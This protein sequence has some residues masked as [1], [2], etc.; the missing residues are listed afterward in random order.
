V[1]PDLVTAEELFRNLTPPKRPNLSGA[2]SYFLFELPGQLKAG[3]L[4]LAVRWVGSTVVGLESHDRLSMLGEKILARAW[5]DLDTPGVVEAMTEAYVHLAKD[6]AQ[7]LYPH[8]SE[9]AQ[10]FAD[11]EKR[12]RLAESIANRAPELVTTLRWQW[13]QLVRS[14]D[15]GECMGR[16]FVSV[17]T[18]TE[19]AWATLAWNLVNPDMCDSVL[20]DLLLDARTKSQ[21]FK[22]ESE[23]FFTP[24]DLCSDRA[25]ELKAQ[26]EMMQGWQHK[27]EPQVLEWL[28]RD[29]IRF[30]LERFERGEAAAWWG[31]LREMTLEDTS[32]EY[33][34]LFEQL[35]ITSLPGW[36]L[37]DEVTRV[38]ILDA[39]ERYL[40]LKTPY[41]QKHLLDGQGAED[42]LAVIKAFLVLVQHRP[43]RIAALPED[44]WAHWVPVFLGPFGYGGNRVIMQ[45]L[46]GTAYQHAPNAVVETFAEKLRC[47]IAK[48]GPFLL[49]DALET[50]WDDAI[51]DLLFGLLPEAREKPPCWSGLLEAL[52]RHGNQE[53]VDTARATL[54][55]P[56][57]EAVGERT[58]A[59]KAALVLIRHAP[60]AS[61]SLISPVIEQDR[62]FGRDLIP[63]LAYDVH[64][65][66]EE[67]VHKL[68]AMQLAELFLWLAR[69][70]TYTTDPDYGGAHEFTREDA[71]RELR[72]GLI[73][74]LEK[75]GTPG[76]CQAI[77]H[78]IE[79]HPDLDWVKSV[80]VEAKKNT[81]RETWRP[82]AVQELLSI[83]LKPRSFLVRDAKELQDAL[84]ETLMGLETILQGKQPAARD[85]W[86]KR[87]RDKYVPTGEGHFSDWT[88]RQLEVELKRRGIVADR[89]VVIRQGEGAAPGE[90]TDIYVTAVIPGVTGG[91][92]DQ[93]RVIIEAKGC[94]NRD[95]KTAMET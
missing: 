56:L 54:Q 92:F 13:P 88:S 32:T 23:A 5:E 34:D 50:L 78:I 84:V 59:A 2:Y 33:R 16:L 82:L 3:D 11:T 68:D 86:D 7:M 94:W 37:A 45:A 60:D 63:T 29:R 67:L 12:L 38:R 64:H 42:D 28:P 14:G 22:Q 55:G 6:H 52:A 90:Q 49:P 76:S 39:G 70:Y 95:L 43:N 74:I 80:L 47:D 66:V 25:R 69:E 21:A 61:W 85:L 73:N 4:L 26:Y 15:L 53:A 83:V 72:S 75:S 36:R 19:K 79:A 10:A 17:G 31:L 51:A 44:V 58:L 1:W 18:P 62:S 71:A 81:L 46:V 24:A 41:D 35:D 40:R 93:V 57:L 87:D 65:R 9:A 91:Q 77:Q 89:E 8:G 30:F 20:L 48:D 27:K